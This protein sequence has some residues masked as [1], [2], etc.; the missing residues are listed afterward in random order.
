MSLKP[1]QIAEFKKRYP[2]ISQLSTDPEDTGGTAVVLVVRKPGRAEFSR[3]LKDAGKNAWRAMRT[4]VLDCTL[5]P[6]RE[7]L[8]ALFEREAGLVLTFGEKLAAMAQ[9]NLEVV[10][11]KL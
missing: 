6:S 4:L 5:H 7:E 2:E 11:K 1:E 8:E 9:A 3:F 10:E